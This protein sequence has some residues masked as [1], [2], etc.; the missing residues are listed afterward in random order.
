MGVALPGLLLLGQMLQAGAGDV[1]V[2][3]GAAVGVG[4]VGGHRPGVLQIMSLVS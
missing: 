1:V 2:F 4:L 3:P